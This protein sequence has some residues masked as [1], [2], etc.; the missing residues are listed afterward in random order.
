MKTDGTRRLFTTAEYDQMIAAGILTEDDRVELIQGEIIVMS[1]LGSRHAACV[2]RL[3]WLFSRGLGEAAI[4]RVQDPIHLDERSEPEPDVALVQPRPD[5]YAQAHPEPEDVLLI[6]EVADT[7]LAYDRQVKIP[8]YARAGVGE[9]WL[10]NLNDH[11]MTVY[12]R[13]TLAGYSET[14]R[15]RP[16]QS[17]SP[18]AFPGLALDVTA[19][20][21]LGSA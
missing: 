2:S 12:R 21:R 9:V 17:L 5:F 8:L 7:S 10:V 3:N 11:T 15:F 18:Q 14:T 13:P 6:V 19:I 1:P 4:V 20:V 16:G